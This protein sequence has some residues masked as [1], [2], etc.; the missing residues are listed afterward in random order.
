ML[1]EFEFIHNIKK[2]FD[3]NFVGDDCAVLPRVGETDLL[4]TTDMLIEDVDFRLTWTTPEFL[5][6]KALAVSLSDIAAMGGTPKWGMLSIGVPEHIWNGPFVDAFYSG[7][8]EVARRY[9]VDL[10][11]GDVSRS[12][13][14]LVIDSIVGGEVQA[15]RALLRSGAKVGDAICVTGSFGG[16]AVGLSLLESGIRSEGANE[17][18]GVLIARQMCPTPRIEIGRKLIAAGVSSCID[19]SD[20]LAADLKHICDASSVGARIYVDRIPIDPAISFGETQ[21]LDR[22]L[23][24]GEDFELLFTASQDAIAGLASAD[25]SMIGEVTAIEGVIEIVANAKMYRL[26]PQGFQHF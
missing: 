24:G 13:D 15:G 21:R 5:G 26:K 1:T 14:K 6:H 4:I 9:R 19:V 3:L 23:F 16:A 2:K 8:F 20:G 22:A 10:I 25:V 11:G 12:P 7:W 18:E 17:A